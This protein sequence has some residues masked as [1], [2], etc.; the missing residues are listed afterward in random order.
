M[1]PLLL[2]FWHSMQ[3]VNRPQPQRFRLPCNLLLRRA[4]PGSILRQMWLQLPLPCHDATSSKVSTTVMQ[5][6]HLAL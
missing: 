6:I 4:R 2:P 3:R 5:N 1:M